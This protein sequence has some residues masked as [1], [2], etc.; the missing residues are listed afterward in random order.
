MRRSLIALTVAAALATGVLGA[1]G[2]AGAQEQPGT[3]VEVAQSN[4]DF[5][6]LVSAVSAA[7]LAETLS[8]EGPFTVFAPTNAAF[9]KLP[10]GTLDALLADPQGALTDVLG[11]HVTSG[12]V[13]S[14]AAIAAAGTNVETL[15]G[16]VAVELRGEDLYVGGA[17]VVT[18]DIQASNGV[19]HVIDT[20]ITEPASTAVPGAVNAGDSGLATA[21]GVNGFVL[22]L[23]IG[24]ALLTSG[25]ASI[26]RARARRQS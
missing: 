5:S 7:G 4:P 22:A 9:E 1:A 24:G 2:A 19:I 11:L 13:G 14:Q 18:T 10:A 15:G 23:L 6:T 21:G 25:S 26:S 12:N 16:P 3:I 20:V 8:G 17:K